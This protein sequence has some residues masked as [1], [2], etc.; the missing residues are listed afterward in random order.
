[1]SAA[2]G[3]LTRRRLDV[4]GTEHHPRYVVWELTLR[5]DHACTHCGSR[6]GVA[7]PD[8]LT[9]DEALR[10]VDQLAALGTKEVVLIGGEAYLH[11]GFLT[12]VRALAERDITAGMTTGGRG[13]DAELARAMREAGMQRVSVSIDGLEATHDRMRAR[14]GS[15]ADGRRALEAL[16][17]VGL[18]VQAN[19]NFNRLNER[20]LEPLYDVLR[21]AGVRNW[22]VQL[23]SPLG[24][25]ADRPEMLFQPFDLLTFLPRLAAVK[26]RGLREGVLIMPG[27]NTGY[28]GPEE[29]LLRSPFEGGDDHFVGCVAGRFVMGIE[30]DGAVK[31]CP[32]LQTS[33]YV[34][35]HTRSASIASIW[36]DTRELAFTR[37]RT[38][39]DLW[40]FCRSCPYAAVCMGGC[41]FTAHAFFGR[42]GNNPYCHFRA[43]EHR[44]RGLRER[45]VATDAASG[46]PFDHGLFEIVVE[47]F[48]APLPQEDRSPE[49]LVKLS[50][51]PQRMEP[52]QP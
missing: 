14:R 2:R 15:F 42:P 5:C 50:R 41:S 30:S 36:N 25:A 16:G 31:G 46:L 47:P 9:T 8:E 43:M 28:F 52:A 49:Q 51:K 10:V 26:A 38:V 6:A 48:D 19:T 21:A 24:R 35:G 44:R 12:I 7:R 22:Q 11:D 37:T 32:S 18:V 17:A 39:E 3:K 34:G 1:M 23:T 45:L 33:H 29:A 27:N 40:G 13:V 4:L 20:E